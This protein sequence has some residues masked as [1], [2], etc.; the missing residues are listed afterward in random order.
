MMKNIV[1]VALVDGEAEF[2]VERDGMT[3]GELRIRKFSDI[4]S[5][6]SNH[7]RQSSSF[8]LSMMSEELAQQGYEVT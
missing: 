6:R 1:Q 4:G 8:R 5:L 7:R 3:L 2:E